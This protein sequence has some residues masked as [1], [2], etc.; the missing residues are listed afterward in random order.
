M[1]R[2][3]GKSLQRIENTRENREYFQQLF[4]DTKKIIKSKLNAEFNQKQNEISNF[5]RLLRLFI[6]SL[7]RKINN[8]SIYKPEEFPDDTVIGM[9]NP[10]LHEIF[11]NVK[12]ILSLENQGIIIFEEAPIGNFILN[13]ESIDP[14][15]ICLPKI[16]T[17]HL[18]R[19]NSNPEKQKSQNYLKEYI[20]ATTDE[21]IVTLLAE[22]FA[23][24]SFANELEELLNGQNNS[25][26]KD[27]NNEDQKYKNIIPNLGISINNGIKYHAARALL[28]YYL[29]KSE[30]VIEITNENAIYFAKKFD[31]NMT[32]SQAK[33]IFNYFITQSEDHHRLGDKMFT[34]PSQRTWMRNRFNAVK[35]IIFNTTN[36][37]Y[38]EQILK[39]RKLFTKE[40]NIL[41]ENI[42]K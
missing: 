19:I 25:E 24:H 14:Q 33:I 7:Y 37:K 11:K 34:N 42:D 41:L 17:K 4:Q 15:V 20:S 40:F 22:Y 3:S 18:Y 9:A 39:M 5:E 36:L 27:G 12:L 31:P 26:S 16:R 1:N 6:N 35:P 23:T 8:L 32:E 10:F 2:Q 38:N 13:G 21:Q 28:I 30:I 29:Y